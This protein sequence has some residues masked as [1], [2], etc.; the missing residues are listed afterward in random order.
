MCVECNSRQQLT[1]DTKLLLQHNKVWGR[2][3]CNSTYS[4]LLLDLAR[5]RLSVQGSVTPLLVFQKKI[6]AS[7]QD[8]KKEKA[9]K[10][11]CFSGK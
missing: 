3:K 11:S 4:C 10:L 7:D 5:W 8:W 6:L 2:C 9:R 1:T